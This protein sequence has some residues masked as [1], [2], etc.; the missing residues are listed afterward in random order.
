MPQKRE[1][2]QLCAQ[3]LYGNEVGG[4]IVPEEEGE[5]LTELTREVINSADL[6]DLQTLFADEVKV[7]N[8]PLGCPT[9]V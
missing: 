2:V 1:F 9:E 5:M 4:V 6:L 8:S 7:P 3:L